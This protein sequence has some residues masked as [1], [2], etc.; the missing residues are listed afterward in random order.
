SRRH[1]RH[2]HQAAARQARLHAGRLSAAAAGVHAAPAPG[3]P[4][5][6]HGAPFEQRF[7]SP[8]H[9]RL[10]TARGD[11]RAPGRGRA[12]RR[13]ALSV[14]AALGALTT[15]RK[16][17]KGRI[18]AEI[19]NYGFVKHLRAD[20]S[21][22]VLR[23]KNGKLRRAGKGLSFWFMPMSTGLAEV[24]VDDRELEFM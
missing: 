21:A 11:R 6:R 19:R 16:E 23:F 1:R 20:P 17:R 7:I 5:D 10:G 3:G 24:P 13:R 15:E 18:M 12:S 14:R 8:P 22:Y 4:R 9:A 2:G